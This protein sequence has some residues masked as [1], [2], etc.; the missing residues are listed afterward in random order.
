MAAV[1]AFRGMVDRMGERPSHW[2]GS[3]AIFALSIGLLAA[4]IAG[5]QDTQWIWTPDSPPGAASLGSACFRKTLQ[6]PAIEQARVTIVADDSWS[7][8]INTMRR[9]GLHVV[10]T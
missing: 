1:V 10:A 4:G 8:W 5:A 6:L 9:S 7:T 2:L 3:L